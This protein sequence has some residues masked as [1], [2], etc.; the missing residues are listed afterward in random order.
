[1]TSKGSHACK[2]HAS[3]ET[4]KGGKQKPKNIDSQNFKKKVIPRDGRVGLPEQVAAAER[5]HR[6]AVLAALMK[7]W[8]EVGMGTSHW[9]ASATW[10]LA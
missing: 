5:D 9:I 3:R 2:R 10:N 4:K 6:L 1:M 7:T 8:E